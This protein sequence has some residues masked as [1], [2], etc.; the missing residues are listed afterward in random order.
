LV[1]RRIDAVIDRGKGPAVVFL[2]HFG[3]SARTAELVIDRLAAT[4]RCFATD[5]AG[6]GTAADRPGPFTVTAAADDV[7]DLTRR[8]KLE[9]FTLVGHSMGGKIA[10]AVAMRHPAELRRLVLLAPSPPTPEPIG[11]TDRAR[12]LANWGNEAA[13]HDIVRMTIAQPIGA[14]AL[15]GLIADMLAVSAAAWRGWL[16]AGSREDITSC[17]AQ[18]GVPVAVLGG[19]ADVH[20]TPSLLRTEVIDRIRETYLTVIANTG[21]LLPLEAP[22]AVA[23]LVA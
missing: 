13:M 7:L 2:H 5:L 17:L 19:M 11:D 14:V 15:D 6:F 8:L 4:H 21:H 16:E 20:I 18:V 3:G 9:N 23:A 22:D 12:L 1:E 10:L